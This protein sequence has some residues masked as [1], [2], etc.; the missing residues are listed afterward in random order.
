M[1]WTILGPED[2]KPQKSP[3]GVDLFFICI[4]VIMGIALSIWLI[5]VVIGL[6]LKILNFI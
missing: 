1:P 6:F 3:D 2:M 5:G 4:L